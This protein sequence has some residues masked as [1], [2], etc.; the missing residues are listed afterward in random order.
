M[1]DFVYRVVDNTDETYWVDDPDSILVS[2]GTVQE[3]IRYL[4]ADPEDIT[5]SINGSYYRDE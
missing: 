1:T 5:D 4:L 3:V 2:F